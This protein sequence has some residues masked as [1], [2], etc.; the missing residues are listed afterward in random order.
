MHQWEADQRPDVHPGP[1]HLDQSRIDE[2]LD[3]GPLERPGELAEVAGPG[4]VVAGHRDRVAP[5]GPDDV[6]DLGQ[7]A[8]HGDAVD[9]RSG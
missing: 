8:E 1:G 2:Q 5:Q 3:T 9:D 4:R 6:G 7:A